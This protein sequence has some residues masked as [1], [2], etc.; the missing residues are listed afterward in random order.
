[1]IERMTG[2]HCNI[3]GLDRGSGSAAVYTNGAR[4]RRIAEEYDL[5][6]TGEGMVL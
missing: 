5:T 3:E 2:G 1:M 4:P 6:D